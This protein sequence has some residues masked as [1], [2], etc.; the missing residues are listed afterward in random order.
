M[1]NFQHNDRRQLLTGW[2]LPGLKPTRARGIVLGLLRGALHEDRHVDAETL[3]RTALTAGDMISLA[4][5]YRALAD[6]EQLGLI[7]VHAFRG[8]RKVY[9]LDVGQSRDHLVNVDTGEISHLPPQSLDTCCALVAAERE[10]QVVHRHV[11]LYV[12]DNR[13]G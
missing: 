2:P 12:R 13:A 11:T 9:E 4:S 5:I 10:V 1:G 7:Q 8:M 6:F 3:Y